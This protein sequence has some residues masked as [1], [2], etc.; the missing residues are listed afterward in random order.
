MGNRP[1]DARTAPARPIDERRIGARLSIDEAQAVAEMSV[2]GAR[3]SID[4]RRRVLAVLLQREREGCQ[5]AL[6]SADGTT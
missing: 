4:E 1:I 5:L 3:L 6:L 2:I